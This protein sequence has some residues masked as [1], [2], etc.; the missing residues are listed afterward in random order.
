MTLLEL[1]YDIYNKELLG[2]VVALKEWR[3]FLQ[4]TTELFVVKIDYKNL[5]SFLTTKELNRRQ[6]R[7]AE[8]LLEYYF[9]IEHVK[10]IDNTRVDIL[11]RKVELQGLE[12][13]SGAI[14][15]L[16][17]DRKIRYN[18]LKLVATYEFKILRSD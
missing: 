4:G 10:G 15:K 7:W 14:L 8:I 5:T 6:V 17:E 11:S 18:H 12:K 16:S 9:E 13:L 2:I 3:A 1:N